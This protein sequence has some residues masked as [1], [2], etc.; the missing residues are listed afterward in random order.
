MKQHALDGHHTPE[1]PHARGA[2]EDHGVPALDGLRAI[3]IAPS[4]PPAIN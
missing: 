2:Q 4:W 3:S 1:A